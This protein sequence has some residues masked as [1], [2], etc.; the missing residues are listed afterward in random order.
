MLHGCRT[1]AICVVS[2]FDE[3]NK[4]GI[5]RCSLGWHRSCCGVHLVG[6]FPL[7]AQFEVH[8]CVRK[9]IL[10]HRGKQ[11]DRQGCCTGTSQ[12][13]QNPL[14][15]ASHSAFTDTTGQGGQ[16]CLGSKETTRSGRL[17]H[18]CCYRDS[19]RKFSCLQTPN[20]SSSRKQAP[21]AAESVFMQQTSPTRKLSKLP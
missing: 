15:F 14:H 5:I 12:H 8:F 11:R 13:L 1:C 3:I 16:C 6:N 7:L 4:H 18:L 2:S 9:D 21:I 10:S 17:I 20:L 19:C